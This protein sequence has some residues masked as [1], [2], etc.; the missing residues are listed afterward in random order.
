MAGV[1]GADV[2]ARIDAILANRIGLRLTLSKRLVLATVAVLSLT[3]PIVT[4]AIEAAAFAAG[5]LPGA[6]AGGLRSIRSCASR[7]RRSNLSPMPAAH[8]AGSFRLLPRFEYSELPIGWLLRSAL[9]K[10]DYQM[11]GAPGWIDTR[12][13]H[14]HGEGA[15]RHAAGRR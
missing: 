10:P 3:V 1:G 2:K 9:Q 13:L 4:G 11:I 15:G 6:P 8:W 14:D 7:W 12:A 5:Q